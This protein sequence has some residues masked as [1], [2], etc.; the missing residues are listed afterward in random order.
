MVRIDLVWFRI[1]LSFFKAIRNT[2]VNYRFNVYR[3][4]WKQINEFSFL[5]LAYK[6]NFFYLFLSKYFLSLP[7]HSSFNKIHKIITLYFFIFHLDS[8]T[9]FLL[10]LL[11]KCIKE[12]EMMMMLHWH[13]SFLFI[14]LGFDMETFSEVVIN[15]SVVRII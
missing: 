1:K 10:L 5:L 6:I 7:F 9:W 11:A 2:F 8:L 14:N 15:R 3:Q 12:R 13:L 4:Y